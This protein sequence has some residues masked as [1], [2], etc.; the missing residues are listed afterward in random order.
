MSCISCLLTK[1]IPICL[2]EM[3]IGKA[4]IDTD[5][6]VYILNINTG[7]ILQLTVTS[8]GA[9]FIVADLSE[10][11]SS[12]FSPNCRYKI[13]VCLEGDS[14]DK[15]ADITMPDGIIT[16]CLLVPI[17]RAFDGEGNVIGDNVV[18]L[19]LDHSCDCA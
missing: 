6:T 7:Y 10:I 13:F 1:S 18:I 9:G 15:P 2:S 14:I 3:T 17:T 4:A 5:Y 19:E 8:N 16:N 12:F 11:E